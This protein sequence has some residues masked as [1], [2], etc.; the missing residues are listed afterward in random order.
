MAKIYPFIAFSLTP[1]RAA[2]ICVCRRE[3]GIHAPTIQ[4]SG[5]RAGGDLP[6]TP[7]ARPTTSA[8]GSSG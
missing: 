8:P 1:G 7:S 5:S 2:K 4:G 6:I 3:R